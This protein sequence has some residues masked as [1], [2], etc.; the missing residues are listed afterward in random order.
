MSVY[1]NETEAYSGVDDRPNTQLKRSRFILAGQPYRTLDFQV[2]AALD[3]LGRRTT[4]PASLRWNRWSATG[5]FGGRRGGKVRLL[6]PPPGGEADLVTI[7]NNYFQQPGLGL[8][9]LF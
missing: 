2:I 4:C 7:I 5:F 9:A 1:D 3:F 6:R 8:V